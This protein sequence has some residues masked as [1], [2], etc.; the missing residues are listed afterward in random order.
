MMST[1]TPVVAFCLFL[2]GAVAMSAARAS[3]QQRSSDTAQQLDAIEQIRSK[4]TSADRQA[5]HHL[6]AEGDKAYRR[7]DYAKA[8]T[9]YANAY[10]NAPDSYAYIMAGDAHWRDVLQY[11]AQPAPAQA[12]DA[13]ACR[14]DNSHFTRDL[15][16]DVAQHQAV[17]IALAEKDRDE[18]VLKSLIDRRAR[19]QVACLQD[20]AR[21]YE[22]EP[23][24]ACVDL[25]QLS[26]CLGPPLIK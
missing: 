18:R 12:G 3:D 1:K 22:T 9:A 15:A 8:F 23:P 17:G 2:C 6:E 16:L 26:H 7:Q 24:T 4:L 14:M 13:A 21:H 25:D 19:A 20:M 10:P 11:H 5:A